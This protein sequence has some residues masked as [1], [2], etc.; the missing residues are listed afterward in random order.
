M[1]PDRSLEDTITH[2]D[3]EQKAEFLRFMRRILQWVPEDRPTA[4][5]RLQDPFM[6]AA[7]LS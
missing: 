7:T 2:I 4:A 3:G 1:V 6:V 5:E